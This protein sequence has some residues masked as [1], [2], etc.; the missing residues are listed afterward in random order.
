MVAC[1]DEGLRAFLIDCRYRFHVDQCGQ[2][3]LAFCA[4]PG[5]GVLRTAFE[6][7]VRTIEA[8]NGATD[9]GRY[10][11]AAADL[12]FLQLGQEFPRLAQMFVAGG[13]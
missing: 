8:Q 12:L 6:N 4:S 9:Q 7:T 11:I 13:D 1:I 3:L 10:V 5:V 2:E